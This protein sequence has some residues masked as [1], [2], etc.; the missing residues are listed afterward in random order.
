MDCTVQQQQQMNQR[1]RAWDN[2]SEALC[3]E[4]KSRTFL[5]LPVSGRCVFRGW[6]A[7]TGKQDYTSYPEGTL[8]RQDSFLRSYLWASCFSRLRA[9]WD[10]E[11]DIW[12]GKLVLFAEVMCWG[13]SSEECDVLHLKNTIMRVQM[14]RWKVSFRMN[15]DI[16]TWF[17]RLGVSDTDVESIMPIACVWGSIDISLDCFLYLNTS[18]LLF[19]SVL[20]L[21]LAYPQEKKN[22]NIRI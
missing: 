3:G 13:V 11:G 10:A 20:F 12:E 14:A 7:L 18:L 22:T 4:I 6:L 9:M 21:F 16:L 17:G 15:S 5:H 1:Q 19:Y 8:T 2:H